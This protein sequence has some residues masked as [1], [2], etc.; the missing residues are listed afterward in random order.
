M[1]NA[2]VL[3]VDDAEEIAEL[4]A[5][6]LEL[7]G[8]ETRM[9]QSGG[10]ALSVAREWNP[11]VVILDLSLPDIDGFEVCRQLRT[12]SMAYILML[13]ARNDEMDRIVGL[14]IGADDY[15]TKPFSPRELAAR[16]NAF[17]RRRRLDFPGE[18]LPNGARH[19]GPLLVDPHAREVC[20]FD[21]TVELTKIEFDILDALTE[22]PKR[23]LTRAEL[24]DRVWGPEWFG[25]DHAVDVHISN[26]RKKLA[27]A[28]GPAVV[29]TV[30]GVGYRLSPH[31][32]AGPP[33]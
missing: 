25:D 23:V 3:V 26:L 27:T 5:E 28:G 31:L 11:D 32:L 15:V 16:V 21:R 7:S 29:T 14:T 4:V 12:F 30:R 19:F 20:L 18:D 33:P 9:S 13:T 8:H 6:I 24:R 17:M 22:K 2:R 10:D 1:A